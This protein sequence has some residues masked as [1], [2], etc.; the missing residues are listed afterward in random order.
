MS[1]AVNIA[2]RK[3]EVTV[4]IDPDNVA[5]AYELEREW[6][7]EQGAD[8]DAAAWAEQQRGRIAGGSLCFAIARDGDRPVGVAE[9]VLS[10]DP[11]TRE[12]AAYAERTYVSPEYRRG[13]T[14]V[15]LAE[16][17]FY[18][19]QF[20]GVKKGRIITLL[21]DTGKFMQRFHEK[22]GYKPV[23]T[24]LEREF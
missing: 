1:T 10:Y 24:V 6:A 13:G 14:T 21:D 18:G 5:A 7:A 17:F 16:A 2:Q 20:I 11:V 8:F 15:A 22:Y 3:I 4:G 19:V 12:V 23:A 9:C